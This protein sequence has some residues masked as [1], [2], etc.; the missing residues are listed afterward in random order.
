M[1]RQPDIAQIPEQKTERH[2]G[3]ADR[4]HN[5]VDADVFR[6]R[7]QHRRKKYRRQAE[8]PVIETLEDE[9]HD[10]PDG[11]AEENAVDVEN[12]AHCRLNRVQHTFREV[13]DFLRQTL[14]FGWIFAGVR[15]LFRQPAEHIFHRRG[16]SL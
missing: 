13:G 11:L 3:D 12:I 5:E 4:R 14:F 1:F 6:F 2:Q 9:I 16:C 8:C 7:N 15:L 10:V